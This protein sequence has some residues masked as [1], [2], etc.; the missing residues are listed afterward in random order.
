ML[1]AYSEGWMCGRVQIVKHVICQLAQIYVSVT[2]RP[3]ATRGK[4][5]Q[6]HPQIWSVP[7]Q[8]HF[9]I[10]GKG[11]FL[12]LSMYFR[13][14]RMIWYAPP[15]ASNQVYISNHTKRW[16]GLSLCAACVPAPQISSREGDDR[17]HPVS[18]LYFAKAQCSMFNASVQYWMTSAYNKSSQRF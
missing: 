11:K 18:F 9:S 10:H 17:A 2:Y 15:L 6:L 5:G 14:N 8:F 13:G 7:P 16:T 3:S 12:S 4:K 1:D